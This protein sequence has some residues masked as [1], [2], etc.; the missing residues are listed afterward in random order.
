[1]PKG[2]VDV[3]AEQGKVVL[4][5]EVGSTELIE[6]LVGKAREVQGVEEVESQLHIPG[7]QA[8]APS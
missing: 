7:Q 3:D 8:P 4:R 6:E 1:M 5:G 2:A